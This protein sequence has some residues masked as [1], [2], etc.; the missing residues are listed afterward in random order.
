MKSTKHGVGHTVSVQQ[1]LAG[2]AGV[3][4]KGHISGYNFL[5][6]ISTFVEATWEENL[7]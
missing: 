3:W 7:G 2:H 1:K 6:V 4:R 5:L